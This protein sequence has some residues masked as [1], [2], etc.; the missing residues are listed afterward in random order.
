MKKPVKPKKPLT[1]SSP[2]TEVITIRKLLLFDESSKKWIAVDHISH[3]E[4]FTFETNYIRDGEAIKEINNELCPNWD[5]LGDYEYNFENGLSYKQYQRI[6]Y[7]LHLSDFTISQ[8]HNEDGYYI[9]SIVE[10]SAA[11]PE[12]KTKLEKYNNRFNLYAEALK[13]Y[14][15][16]LAKYEDYR[17]EKRR[18]KLEK[19]L[20]K[21]K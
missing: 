10:Y 19:E 2:P 6:A 4:I 11:D 21:L 15:V 12:Y 13:V 17:K 3:P 18:E 1:T 8:A 14:E 5:E 20:Q 7:D 9:H 16:E